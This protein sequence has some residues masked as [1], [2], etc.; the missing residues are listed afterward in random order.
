MILEYAGIGTISMINGPF[1]LSQYY[2]LQ[3]L[4]PRDN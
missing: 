1:T 2:V 4:V 3:I